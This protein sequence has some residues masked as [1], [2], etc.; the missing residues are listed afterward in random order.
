MKYQRGYIDLDITGLL[1]FFCV[2]GAVGGIAVWNIAE[3]AWPLIKTA[4][5]SM[6][7]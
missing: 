2:V 1:I 4:I 3:W 6:T 5:H 7:E